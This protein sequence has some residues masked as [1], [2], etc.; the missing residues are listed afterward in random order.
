MIDA[1]CVTIFAVPPD[2]ISIKDDTGVERSTVVGPYAEGDI[3]TLSCEVFG[4][5][6]FNTIFIKQMHIACTIHGNMPN[7]IES[8]QRTVLLMVGDDSAGIVMLFSVVNART[9]TKKVDTLTLC[10]RF[11]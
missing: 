9:K 10:Y 2:R 7:P 5:K 6:Y 3:I 8:I 4:G 11:S 1:F